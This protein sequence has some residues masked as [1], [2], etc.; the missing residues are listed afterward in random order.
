MKTV[1]MPALRVDPA[2]RD[3]AEAVLEENETLSAFMEA[4]LREGIARRQFQRAFISRG[5]A[6]R[7]EAR[8]TGEYFDADDVHAEL[9]GLLNYPRP[10]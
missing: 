7:D 1:P 4:A 8:R 3:A 9:E 6:T 5:L 10:R 2:L